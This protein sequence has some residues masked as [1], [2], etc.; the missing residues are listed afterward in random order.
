MEPTIPFDSLAPGACAIHR[1]GRAKVLIARIGDTV[2]AT[3]AICTHARVELAAGRLTPDCL[4]ECPS[5]GALFSPV[6]GAVHEGPATE[7]LK[8]YPTEIVDGIVHVDVGDDADATPSHPSPSTP[9]A[10]PSLASWGRT[11][12]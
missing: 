2:H 6:D 10:R 11:A 7:P 8:T 5:H 12:R 4:V 3:T 9:G 1:I